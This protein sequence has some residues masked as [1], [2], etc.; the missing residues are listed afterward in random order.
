MSWRSSSGWVT[1]TAIS[2]LCIPDQSSQCGNPN[3]SV[4]RSWV[5]AM[6]DSLIHVCMC[7]AYRTDTRVCQH[8]Y[9]DSKTPGGIVNDKVSFNS[10]ATAGMTFGCR[11]VVKRRMQIFYPAKL[12]HADHMFVCH[13]H[14]MQN[15]AATL[16]KMPC[17]PACNRPSTAHTLLVASFSSSTS[18]IQTAF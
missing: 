4:P 15:L 14:S 18:H 1:A 9:L 10:F 2:T 16:Q 17:Q 11:P 13:I 7:H 3:E 5:V 8:Q 12:S 6:F